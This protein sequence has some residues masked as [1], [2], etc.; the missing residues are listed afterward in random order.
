L[1]KSIAGPAKKIGILSLGGTI[2]AADYI[3]AFQQ[4]NLP[5]P[6]IKLIGTPNTADPGGANTEN[7]L[8]IQLS[9]AAYSY[10][11]GKAADITF[12]S[13]PNTDTGM[14]QGL[15]ALVSAGCKYN[16]ISWGA[17]ES[18]WSSSARELTETAL[19]NAIAAQCLTTVAS[20]DN[21]IDD[22]TS[23]AMCDYPSGSAYALAIGGTRLTIAADGTI[24]EERAWGDGRSGDEGGGGGYDTN[25]PKPTYQNGIVAG[26]YRGSPDFS[27][28]ADP[29]TGYAIYSD[30]QW[31]VVGGTSCSSPLACGMLAA[32]SAAD[33]PNLA[34]VLYGNKATAF[35]DIIL[36]SNGEPAAP[37]WDAASGLG[38]PNGPGLAQALSGASPGPIPPPSGGG[39]PGGQPVPIPTPPPS[40]TLQQKLDAVF[41]EL[42]QLY[43][44]EVYLLVAINR[45]ID[46]IL[47]HN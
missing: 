36:G 44:Q 10:M 24:T 28:N 14:A 22:N 9:A 45:L 4:F 38:S 13:A 39:G 43:P 7:A 26:Q 31:G 32:F 8:D 23:S 5:A 42:E 12:C 18:Q 40:Q 25:T 41:A 46:R 11:T 29:V 15:N 1:P 17:P 37:G 6:T 47:F 30:G 2:N 35:R 20:G 34:S 27:A 21:S 33:I 16:S 3:I 19:K